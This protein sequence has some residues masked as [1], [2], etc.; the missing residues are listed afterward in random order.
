M[1][2][3]GKERNQQGI[4]S[5]VELAAYSV[6]SFMQNG[7]SEERPIDVLILAAGLGTRMRSGLAK[8]LHALNGRPLI[9]HVCSAAAAL[10]P[11]KIYVV[12][13]HQGEDVKT[14]VLKELDPGLLEFVVQKEQLGTGDAVN[15]ARD[16]LEGRDSTI[17][18]LS[19]DVPLIRHET[20]AEMVREHHAAKASC[21]ILTVK[22]HDPTGYGRIIR[23]N[24]GK[25]D[26]IVEQKDAADGELAVSE[27][28]S[29]IYCF[30]TKKL[31]AALAGVRTIT[32]RANT[33]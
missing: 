23:D 9:D 10:G 1:F 2:L 24:D 20:L 22:L 16:F 3:R 32:H 6:K 13:G 8:V 31:F 5:L 30:D 14:A 4:E 7:N 26:R 12:I 25:F 11:K 15:A 17:V 27:I 19:G 33:I 21:T 29:G 28:N 18:V